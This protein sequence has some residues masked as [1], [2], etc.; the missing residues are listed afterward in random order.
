MTDTIC[1]IA[2]PAGNGGVAIIRISGNNALEISKGIFEPF[3]RSAPEPRK[4][5]YGRLNFDAVTDDC[6]GLYFPAP[7]SFTGEEVVELQIH[8]GYYLANAVVNALI[9]RG[10]RLA[11]R[12]EFSKRAVLNGRMDMSQAEGI[13]DMINANSLTALRAGSRLMHGTMH[14]FVEELQAKLTDCLCEVN[15]ALDYP[16]HDIEY[17]TASKVSEICNNLV[18]D[19]NSALATAATGVKVKN[20]V[21]VVLAGDPNVG[22]SSLL[23]ALIGYDRAIVTDI[24]GTTRDTISESYEYNGMLFNVTDTAGLR[25]TLDIVES[26]G[27]ERARDEIATADI[28]VY[29]TDKMEL[30]PEIENSN[31]LYVLNK[32]DLLNNDDLINN[33]KND[34][35]LSKNGD[36]LA[37]DLIISAKTGENIQ[38]LKKIIFEKTIDTELVNHEILLTNTRHIECLKRAKSALMQTIENCNNTTLDILSI[39]LMQAWQ[40]LGEITGTTASEHIIDEIFARFCLGK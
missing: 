8:G 9:S 30:R 31:V 15:V 5:I 33:C 13:I 38:E 10:A 22:K 26:A 3:S 11:E 16:E 37:F 21:K 28:V 40:D 20:G 2:T 18:K 6:I 17:I 14:K 25:T 7:N 29:V 36:K 12:G 19:I 39:T 27:I 35:N 34:K 4:A 23:N 24:A 32:S 1:A